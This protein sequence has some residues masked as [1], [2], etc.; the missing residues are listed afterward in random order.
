MFEDDDLSKNMGELFKNENFISLVDNM[1]R[2]YG[3]TPVEILSE[4]TIFDFTLNVAIMAKA[5]SEE[6]KSQDALRNKKGK[7]GKGFGAFGLAHKVV[8]KGKE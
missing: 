3:K 8:K 4:A 2:R 7:G 5:I 6:V 1:A